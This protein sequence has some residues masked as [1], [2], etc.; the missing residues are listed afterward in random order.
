MSVGNTNNPKKRFLIISSIIKEVVVWTVFEGLKRMEGEVTMKILKG[1][2]FA[3][4]TT[5]L[6]VGPARAG[7]VEVDKYEGTSYYSDDG[8]IKIV[9]LEKG[10][11]WTIVDAKKGT[12]TMVNPKGRS[13]AKHSTE[14]FCEFMSAITEGW[15]PETRAMVEQADKERAARK[16][17]KVSVRKVGSGGV[18]AGY[19]TIKY[20]VTVEGK[21]HLDEDVWIATEGSI[22]KDLMKRMK[23]FE[24]MGEKM[25]EEMES[26]G[27]GSGEFRPED[28]PQYKK[29]I[30]KGW[31]MKSVRKNVGW[32]DPEVVKEVVKLE[33]RKIP[34]SEFQPPRGYKKISFSEMMG[35]LM[36][37]E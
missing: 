28:S 16:P 36:A 31:L 21:P 12:M 37:G 17:P 23:K 13:Y 6:F 33:K 25:E 3:L 20:S 24:K 19:K 1:I 11:G 32:G 10:E 15:S 18:I 8:K 26:C 22:I 5:L 30:L 4:I 27:A 2:V 35:A 34:A 14:E 29:L 9:P 7:W